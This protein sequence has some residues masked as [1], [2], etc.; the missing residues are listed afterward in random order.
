MPLVH[1][2]RAS[3]LPKSA[4]LTS[5]VVPR[6]YVPRLKLRDPHYHAAFDADWSLRNRT[7]APNAAVPEEPAAAS[8]TAG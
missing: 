5:A 6:T 2:R 4:T 3:L 7:N 1:R 8:T